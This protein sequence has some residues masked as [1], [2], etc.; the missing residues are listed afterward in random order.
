M[1][2]VEVLCHSSIRIEK[3]NKVIYFD[4]FRVKDAKKDA[5][6]IYITHSHYDHFSEEDIIKLIKESTVIIVPKDLEDKVKKLQFSKDNVVVVSPGKEYTLNDIK[7]STIPAYN[8]DK[9]FH[10][11]EF[12]WVGY[13]VEVD[14]YKYYIAG[15]TDIVDENRRVICDVAF[16]PIGGTYTMNYKEAARLVNEIKPK[17]VVPIHYAEII[18]SVEDAYDFKELV[19]LDIKCEILL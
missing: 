18:G 1:D 2:G 14:G 4:P 12:G 9:E 10:K 16:V 15:D 11:K 7:F 3:K 8:I 6:Y 17:I 5:D 19:D 13:I